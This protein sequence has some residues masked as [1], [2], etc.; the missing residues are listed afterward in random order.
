MPATDQL[1]PTITNN[2]KNVSKIMFIGE[3]S[4]KNV[5]ITSAGRDSK[6]I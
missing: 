3:K 1:A 4:I 6:T 5:N 2:M